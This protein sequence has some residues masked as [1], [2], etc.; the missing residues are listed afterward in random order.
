MLEKSACVKQAFLIFVINFSIFIE[1]EEKIRY[2]K[3]EWLCGMMVR[4]V[5]LNYWMKGMGY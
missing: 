5:C 3:S 2:S 4:L 1:I